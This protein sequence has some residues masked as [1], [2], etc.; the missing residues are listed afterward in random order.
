MFRWLIWGGAEWREQPGFERG[1]NQESGSNLD[2]FALSQARRHEAFRAG[3]LIA[4]V[5]EKILF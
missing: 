4:N 1:R 3:N 2:P 5:I